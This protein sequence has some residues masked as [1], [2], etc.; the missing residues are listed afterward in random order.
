MSDNK[1]YEYKVV[2]W[3]RFS[4]PPVLFHVVMKNQINYLGSKGWR[5]IKILPR[6]T[7]EEDQG[8]IVLERLGISENVIL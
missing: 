4:D 5:V 3:N 7:A 8:A 2:M 1:S 6:L